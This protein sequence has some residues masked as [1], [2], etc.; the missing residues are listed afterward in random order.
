[1]RSNQLKI[2]SL[3]LA[4]LLVAPAAFAAKPAP[5]TTTSAADEPPDAAAAD[6]SSSDPPVSDPD[7]ADEGEDLTQKTDAED[8]LTETDAGTTVPPEEVADPNAWQITLGARY[9]LLVAPQFLINAFGVEGGTTVV[10]NGGGLDIGFIKKDYGIILSGWYATYPMSDTPFKVPGDGPGDWEMWNSSAGAFYITAD[11]L[12][13]TPIAKQWDWTI[14]AS[15]GIGIV[16]GNL[17]RRETYWT[18]G[19]SDT[20]PGDPYR[21]LIK[22]TDFSV[23]GCIGD[24]TDAPPWPVYPWLSFQTGIRYQ[25]VRNFIARLDLGAGSSG[26]WLGLGADYGL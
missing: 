10:A 19:F 8:E 21:D 14:G 18:N 13:K 1:M 11:F 20:N 24:N 23:Q 2:G 4:L 17:Q 3:A 16:T 22:C 6:L 26:F 5:A 9:R 7:L 15:G 25:P 12:L